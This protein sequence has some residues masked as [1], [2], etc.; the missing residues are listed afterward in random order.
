MGGNDVVGDRVVDGFLEGV[1]KNSVF[2]LIG[3]GCKL[4]IY[5]V[6]FKFDRL[7][8]VVFESLFDDIGFFVGVFDEFVFGDVGVEF[9][10]V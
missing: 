1:S 8:G 5:R 4:V 10:E 2:L 6:F 9:V 3:I 7:F